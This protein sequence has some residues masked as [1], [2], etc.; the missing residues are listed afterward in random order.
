MWIGCE[1]CFGVYSQEVKFRLIDDNSI[2]A[3]AGVY[4]PN[5]ARDRRIL[6][7]EL[8]GLMSWWNLP[9]CIG[10]DFIVTRFPSERSE[11][12][13]RLAMSDFSDFLHEQ[14]LLDLPLAG[15]SFYLVSCSR[16]SK[17][18]KD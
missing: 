6:W 17:V 5:H 11:V 3:F 8:A 1:D 2:W 10:G 18:V 13:C 16:S 14:G 7:D 9:W 4:G 12:A 15:G